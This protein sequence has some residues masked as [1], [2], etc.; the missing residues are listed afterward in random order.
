MITGFLKYSCGCCALVLL[1]ITSILPALMNL[2]LSEWVRRWV[3]VSETQATSDTPHSNAAEMESIYY[4]YKFFG[5]VVIFFGCNT[6][7]NYVI[8]K[9][10]LV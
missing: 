6:L 3:Q 8:A 7:R 9:I 2:F 4:G 5:I 10:T 1:V